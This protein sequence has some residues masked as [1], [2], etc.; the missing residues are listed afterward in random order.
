MKHHVSLVASLAL[1][2]LLAAGCSKVQAGKAELADICLDR[3]GA[4]QAKCE[5]YVGTLE[6]GLS[7]ELFQTVAQGAYDNRDYA[8]KD[9]L[10]VSLK[11]QP[12]IA[13]TLSDAMSICFAQA[14]IAQR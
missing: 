3:Y 11:E 9:W 6:A 10:P 13:A 2:T 12:V 7:P 8:N 1:A 5:C 4:S 14:T